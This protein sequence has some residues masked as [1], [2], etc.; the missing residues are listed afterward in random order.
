MLQV[1]LNLIIL[2]FMTALI[3]IMLNITFKEVNYMS[4]WIGFVIMGVGLILIIINQ[5]I[6]EIE[7]EDGL[8]FKYFHGKN[9]YD[10]QISVNTKN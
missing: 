8:L 9:K 7:C 4:I 10:K 1:G 5:I 3:N 6:A 2:G